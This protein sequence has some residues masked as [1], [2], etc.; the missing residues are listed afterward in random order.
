MGSLYIANHM[1]HNT[2]SVLSY[3]A[4]IS[5]HLVYLCVMIVKTV[6]VYVDIL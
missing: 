2:K 6:Y 3:I 1:K 4:L 5:H